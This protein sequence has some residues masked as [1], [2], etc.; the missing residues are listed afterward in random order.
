MMRFR[1]VDRKKCRFL[2]LG[3]SFF[4]GDQG[5][6]K[7]YYAVTVTPTGGFSGTVILSVSGLP[8]GAIPSFSPAW[9]NGSGSSTLTL[10]TS[11]LS[12]QTDATLTITGTGIV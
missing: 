8:L 3:Q 11:P 1:N 9:V 10:W 5:R 7:C 12:R 4:Q 6:A 2:A